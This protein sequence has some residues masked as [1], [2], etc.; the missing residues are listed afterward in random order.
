MKHNLVSYSQHVKGT[1]NDNDEIL[2][3][4]GGAGGDNFVG[5]LL[6]ASSAQAK[7]I[8]TS[9]HKKYDLSWSRWE[10]FTEKV[11]LPDPFLEGLRAYPKVRLICAFMES[12]RRGDYSQGCTKD[13][14][15]ATTRAAIDNVASTFRVCGRSNPTKDT[16]GKFHLDV[17]RQLRGYRKEDPPPKQEKALPV[18][19]YRWILRHTK[20]NEE[21][22]NTHLLAGA[23]FFAMRSCEYSKIGWQ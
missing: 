4:Y 22:A 3:I 6:G 21:K 12:V 9:T 10:E 5:L 13:I 11:G 7:D 14:Q 2:Q 18:V 23:F 1:H 15:S 17:D 19:V 16:R 8:E 20:T